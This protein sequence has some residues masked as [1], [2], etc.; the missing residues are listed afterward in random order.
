MSE[1]DNNFDGASSRPETQGNSTHNSLK[2]QRARLLS[3]LRKHKSISTIEAREKLDVMHPA[4]RI[5]ELKSQ[6]HD[7]FTDKNYESTFFGGKHKCGRYILI[8]EAS[9]A[10]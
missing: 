8:R 10:L 9:H 1:R 7:I 5:M 4:A 2:S 6:G 3:Y